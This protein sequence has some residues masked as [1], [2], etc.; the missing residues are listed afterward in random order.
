MHYR[1]FQLTL[2]ALVFAVTGSL[3]AQ[4][5][6][7]APPRNLRIVGGEGPP[8]PAGP[9][10]VPISAGSDLQQVVNSHPEGATFLLK[11]GIHRLQSITPR[12][13]QEFIGEPGTIL[14]GARVLTNWQESGSVW[15]VTGQTQQGSPEGFATGVCMPEAVRC[16][17]PE[18]LFFDD[19][20]LFHTDSLANGGPGKWFF[21]YAA[22]RIY[23]WDNPNG[24]RVETSVIPHAFSGN[25]TGVRIADLI[26]EKYASRASKAAIEGGPGWVIE[27]TEV[28]LN[29]GIGIRM[30]NDRRIRNNHIHHNGQLGIGGTAKNGLVEGNEIDHNNTRGFDSNWEGGGAKFTFSDNL[31]I[32]NNFSHHNVGAGLWTDIDNINITFEY[33]RCED[34]TQSGITHET[35]YKAII[36]FNTLKRNGSTHPW[37]YWVDGSGIYVST[38][39][40]VEVYGNTLEDNWQGISGLDEDRG[41]GAHGLYT[42]SNFHVHDNTIRSRTPLGNGSGRTGIAGTPATF[43]SKNNRFINNTYALGPY[44]T[45]FFWLGSEHTDASWRGLGQDINGIFTR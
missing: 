31:T 10:P 5:G 41:S 16:L 20:P 27:D 44:A 4:S 6:P 43:S 15:Y 23:V 39:R 13:H 40:D 14:S 29:H 19:E 7:P 32:R 11:A 3:L 9:P 38:S 45:Y 18:D 2:A 26:I 36:R 34:N 25:A 35:G 37:P 22:D 42:L 17:Y 12:E 30:A 21:D 8:G 1:F 24:R 28:R 33:N